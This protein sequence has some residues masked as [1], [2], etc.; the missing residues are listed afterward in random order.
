MKPPPFSTVRSVVLLIAGL[1]GLGYEAKFADPVNGPLVIGFL[2]MCFGG[3][4]LNRDEQSKPPPP[5]TPAPT[6]E[7]RG[8]VTP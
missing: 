1:V 4:I 5:Q 2:G 3:P 7:G 8:D 6:P